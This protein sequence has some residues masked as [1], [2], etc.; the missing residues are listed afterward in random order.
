CRSRINVDFHF[1]GLDLAF[2]G[3]EWLRGRSDEPAL[4]L[5]EEHFFA[6]VRDVEA[7]DVVEHLL[8]LAFF[9]IELVQR[10]P[11]HPWRSGQEFGD[12]DRVRFARKE[13]DEVAGRDRQCKYAL[14]DTVEIYGDS[15]R[16]FFVVRLLRGVGGSRRRISFQ[17]GR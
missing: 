14:A 11:G 12:E 9:K 1:L 5:T 7:V 8:E 13:A 17:I 16:S 6:V 2:A 10:Q 4:A 15:R 3:F